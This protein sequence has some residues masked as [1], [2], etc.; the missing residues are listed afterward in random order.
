MPVIEDEFQGVDISLV[1]IGADYGGDIVLLVDNN[2]FYV[3]ELRL[4]DSSLYFHEL[5]NKS[6]L[7]LIRP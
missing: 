3:S 2:V 6:A 1:P 4:A 5:S 7:Y